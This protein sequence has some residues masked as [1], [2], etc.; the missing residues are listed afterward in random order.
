MRLSGQNE[1]RFVASSLSTVHVE[2]RHPAESAIPHPHCAVQASFAG[3][4]YSVE[5]ENVEQTSMHRA[6]EL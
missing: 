1:E 4:G 2:P 3:G 6:R 5:P